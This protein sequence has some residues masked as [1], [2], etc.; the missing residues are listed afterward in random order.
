MEWVGMAVNPWGWWLYESHCNSVIHEATGLMGPGH[1][2]NALWRTFCLATDNPAAL[3]IMLQLPA[4]TSPHY[5][6]IG[7][8]NVT[9][10]SFR[11]V[12]I[13]FSHIEIFERD[14]N[15]NFIKSQNFSVTLGLSSPRAW[16]ITSA[17]TLDH[18]H[19]LSWLWPVQASS[20]QFSVHGR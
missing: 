3:Q 12:S 5:L 11:A 1:S 13:G 9:R 6:D 14:F 10:S 4:G 20:N 16:C 7:H 18:Q 2:S 19:L 15:Q 8:F 17:S